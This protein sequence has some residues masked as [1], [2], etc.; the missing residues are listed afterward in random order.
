MN[1]KN[2]K[3][4]KEF[5]LLKKLYE[6]INNNNFFFYLQFLPKNESEEKFY[7]KDPTFDREI[8]NRINRTDSLI[9]QGETEYTNGNVQVIIPCHET[10]F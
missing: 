5:I 3:Q 8:K 10:R 1:N 9:R 4:V 6:F 7:K 2:I